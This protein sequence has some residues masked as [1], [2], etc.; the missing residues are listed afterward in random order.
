[1]NI[2]VYWRPGPSDNKKYQNETKSLE[3]AYY[4]FFFML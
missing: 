1:M 2:T 4:F 3:I